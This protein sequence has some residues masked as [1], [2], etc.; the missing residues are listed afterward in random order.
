[1]IRVP[2]L[3][4]GVVTLRGHREDDVPAVL[5]QCTDPDTQAWTSVPAPYTLD[6]AKTFVRHVVPGGW[7][8]DAEWSFA[9]VVPDLDGVERFAGGVA[10]SNRGAGL[11]ELGYATSPWARGRGV[12][13]RACRLLLGWGFEERGLRAVDWVAK[14]WNWP[15]RRVAWRL[16]FAVGQ[17]RHWMQ[18]RDALVPAWHGTLA[19]GEELTPRHPWY[20]APVLRGAGVVLRPLDDAD[21]PRML[22]SLQ[23]PVMQHFSEGPRDRAPH[24]AERWP[25]LV[26]ERREWAARGEAVAWTVADPAT[27]AHLGLVQLYHLSHRRQ[28]ELGFWAHPDARGRGLA[29]QAVRLALRHAFVPWQDGGLGLRRVHAHAVAANTASRR[30]LTAV[31]L[32]ETGRTRSEAL[33]G[34]GTW[35]DTARYDVLAEEWAD[36]RRP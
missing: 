16:G 4:D 3:S 35:S 28:A 34:D 32:H 20:D 25:D 13:E 31:G 27:D 12:T 5:E 15:S 2:T 11:A 24:T 18:Q 8:A 33:L 6:D 36:R 19:R 29:T 14:R 7:Q 23:D 21:L 1:M 10:L 17:E 9:V 30:V 22:E 26:E